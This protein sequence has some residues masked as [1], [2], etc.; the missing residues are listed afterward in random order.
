VASFDISVI[1]PTHNRRDLLAG[2]LSSLATQTMAADRWELIVVDDGSTDGTREMLEQA[3]RGWPTSFTRLHRHHLRTATVRNAGA[4]RASGRV[5][6]FLDDDMV[7]TPELVAAHEQCHGDLQLAVI[8][9]IIAPAERRDPWTSWDDAQLALLAN[10]LQGGRRAPG[11]RDFYSGNCSIAAE[12]FRSVGGFS[13]SMERAED[14][15][16]GYR[17]TAVGTRLVYCEA[18]TSVHRGMHSFG[19][20]VNNAAAFG[21][22][23]VEMAREFGHGSDFLV[24]YRSRHLLN[25]ILVRLCSRYPFLEAPLVASIDPIGRL[26]SAVGATAVSSAAYSAIYNLSY[27]QG[28]IGAFGSEGFWRGVNHRPQSVALQSKLPPV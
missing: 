3:A 1:V 18:A 16:L 6:L 27:W 15:D 10:S 14:F 12:L 23:E 17:L 21:R 7:A 8:G 25:R 5:L 24:W 26:G 13:T 9:R 22:A 4:E 20:W 2:L 19:N 28:L 11:P